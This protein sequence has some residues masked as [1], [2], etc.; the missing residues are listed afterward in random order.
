MK[1]E[2]DITGDWV[3]LS[4]Y[5][6]L[7]KERDNARHYEEVQAKEARRLRERAEAAEQG[8][9][10]YKAQAEALEAEEEKVL[11]KLAEVEGERNR[12]HRRAEHNIAQLF[13]AEAECEELRS[14]TET[15]ESDY[16]EKARELKRVTELNRQAVTQNVALRAG[17]EAEVEKLE[18]VL[19]ETKDSDD[20]HYGFRVGARNH[21]HRLSALLEG[22]E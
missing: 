1:P 11:A 12:A 13:N 4:S 21:A 9:E 18:E 16:G 8:L 10:H 22:S 17:V 2:L 20:F 5:E 19:A 7:E 14:Q 3:K 15:W 6:Q